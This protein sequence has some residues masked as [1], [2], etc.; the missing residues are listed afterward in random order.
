MASSATGRSVWAAAERGNPNGS[1]IANAIA[2]RWRGSGRDSLAGVKFKLRLSAKSRP[3]DVG[4]DWGSF[5][6]PR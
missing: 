3:A 6:S 2:R 4:W 1:V 5:A